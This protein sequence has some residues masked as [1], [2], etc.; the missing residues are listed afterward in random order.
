M[1][2]T[3]FITQN[4]DKWLGFEKKL[5]KNDIDLDTV[6]KGYHHI[7]DDLAYAKT[8]Y[9]NRSIKLYLNS[10]AKKIH[11]KINTVSLFSVK[12]IFKFWK[13]DLIL[14]SFKARKEI[15]FSFILFFV[16][17]AIGVFSTIMDDSFPSQVLSD[18]YVEMTKANIEKGDPMAVYK[19]MEPFK[20]F[21]R[22][23]FN[24]LLVSFKVFIEGIFFGLGSILSLL[25]HGVMVGAFQTYFINEGVVFDS[26][27]TIWMHGSIEIP[28]II[29]ACS[30]GLILGKGFLFPQTYTYKQSIKIHSVY[31]LKLFIGL[32][33]FIILAALI[34]GFVTRF[35]DLNNIIR[36][37]FILVSVGFMIY[38]FWIL[39]KMRSKQGK[40]K[41]FT[42]TV[43]L[44]NDTENIDLTEPKK[45][46]QIFQE[47]FTLFISKF[48]KLFLYSCLLSVIFVALLQLINSARIEDKYDKIFGAPIIRLFDKVTFVFSPSANM[49]NYLLAVLLYGS[50][51]LLTIYLFKKLKFKLANYVTV[52]V[53]FLLFFL[54]FEFNM[55]A[56]SA[57]IFFVFPLLIQVVIINVYKQF[58]LFNSILYFFKK[59]SNVYFKSLRLNIGL[60]LVFF[61]IVYIVN[62]PLELFISNFFSSTT[63]IPNLTYYLNIFNNLIK[64]VVQLSYFSVFIIGNLLLFFSSEEIEN[65]TNL[66]EKIAMLTIQKKAYGIEKE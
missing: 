52:F 7:S 40:Y 59:S 54:F 25:F 18:R 66:K 8:H 58:T 56:T 9:N 2:E 48:N 39:P 36:A 1:K 37:L 10:L 4:K 17:L 49:A 22:I 21:L 23:G 33:P 16:G 32:V 12:D 50:F 19:K 42:Q 30:A 14:I 62:T 11:Q 13:D 35:T 51:T 5:E 46:S 53:V 41:Q 6:S 29:L 47:T 44:N 65:A 28:C 20:M 24:N 31:A 34:E 61:L 60:Y 57:L 63:S 43:Y 55:F 45:N 38:Y 27:L 26:L 15:A 64:N 3:K